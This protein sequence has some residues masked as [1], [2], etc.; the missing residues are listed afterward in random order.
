M[1]KDLKETKIDPDELCRLSDLGNA[2]RLVSRHKDNLRFCHS[3][4]KWLVWDGKR[5][6][7]DATAEAWRY[8]IKTVRHIYA[9][10]EGI[11]QEELRKKLVNHALRSENEN[12][13]RAM[14]SLASKQEGIPVKPEELDRD[15]WLLNVLNG[16]VDLRI[17]KLHEHS[18]QD[19]VT[20]L[21]P[22]NYEANATCPK[23]LEFLNKIMIGKVELIK[24]LQRVV[25]Y[26]LTG[27]TG[28]HK[29]FFLFGSGSNGKTTFLKTLQGIL[30]DYA[31]KTASEIL[32][33]KPAGAHTTAITDL[34]G[35]R[36][37][38]TV[39]IQEGRRLAEALTKELTGGDS[40][41]ARRMR[42][43]NMTFEP[44]HKIILAANHKPIVHETTQALWR[45]ID[46]VPFNYVFPDEERI[47]DYH[48]ILLNEEKDEI[49]LW[50]L[51]GCLEWQKYGL[52]EPPEVVEA[53]RDYRTEMD[54]LGDFM[55]D[56]CV[57]GQLEE[58]TN[59]EL[60]EKY[61]EWCKKNGEKEIAPKAF[62]TRLQERGFLKA[63]NIK[64]GISRGRGWK[65]IGIR[66]QG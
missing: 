29:L 32:I 43:D 34:K 40:V 19:L 15:A 23:W 63:S 30:G 26:C 6:S 36:L 10:A 44:T 51:Q 54:I 5:W 60:R 38:I 7:I 57:I 62:S 9:E 31:I 53:T 48:E 16:T 56:C 25:G 42:E 50:I 27:K 41:T 61:D 59:K 18:R 52:S 35:T 4:N 46:L 45:R 37:A 33:A 64:S 8:A 22:I 20:K 28:E 17:G 39:E 58:V 65:G 13:I 24:F 12:K 11:E 14:L 66:S 49:F 55:A 21:A 47:K 3:W 2:E 1:S